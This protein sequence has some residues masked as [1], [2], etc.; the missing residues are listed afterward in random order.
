MPSPQRQRM[1]SP[2]R[3]MIPSPQRQRMPSPQRQMMPSPPKQM[4]PSPPKERIPSPQRQRMPSPPKERIPS[5]Q[6]Q[7]IP[8]PPKQRMPSPPKERIPSPQRQMMPSPQRQM[9]PSPQRQMMPSPPRQR[10]IS[11]PRQKPT[12]PQR[13]TKSP[14]PKRQLNKVVEPIV[15]TTSIKV[16]DDLYNKLIGVERYTIFRDNLVE[17]IKRLWEE[18]RLSKAV[19]FELKQGLPAFINN[20]LENIKRAVNNKVFIDEEGD[21]IKIIGPGQAALMIGE[22]QEQQRMLLM[23]LLEYTSR[24]KLD[25]ED[26]RELENYCKSNLQEGCNLPCGKNENDECVFNPKKN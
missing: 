2:Q 6:R 25:E 26:K 8:S 24:T 5:P 21:E 10:A 11:P 16:I 9:M 13:E 22:I 20:Q 18:G 15:Q 23:K 4:I 7:M 19:Y 3:Q 12:S 14:I 1:P 17:F